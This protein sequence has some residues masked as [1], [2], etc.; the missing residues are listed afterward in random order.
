[1]LQKAIAAQPE[2]A[3][4][5]LALVNLYLRERDF[6][7][8]LN[9][10]QEAAAAVPG[11]SR[12]LDALGRAQLASGDTNQA[13]D[14]FNRLV[15]AEPKSAI[16]LLRL[17]TVYMNRKEPEKAADALVRAQKLA[18]SD[19]NIARDLAVLYTSMGRNDEAM[20]QAKALQVATPRSAAGFVLEGDILANAK[21]NAEAE[22][23]YREALKVE[24]TAG[25]AAIKLHG[26]MGLAGRKA[27]ADAFARKWVSDYPKDMGF[28]IYIA[29][30]ALRA[31]D[32][33]TVVTHYQAVL[34]QQHDNVVALN[35]MAWAM[36][37]LGDPKAM[38]YAERA[39]KLTPDNPSVLDTVGGLL[40]AKGDTAKGLE[41][42]ARAVQLAP[43]R[44]DLRLN[45]AKALMKAGK[46]DEARKELTQLQAV[47]QDFPGKPEVADLLKK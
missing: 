39:L 13:L 7:S 20:K 34:E 30:R 41:Y 9:A 44:H 27:D 6:R 1:V 40:V 38:G 28:R 16:P 2:S 22:K 47:S 4:A 32:Y 3:N 33:K 23:A 8:A 14:S 37:Q 45:Y 25:V 46:R 26:L 24:P 43:D 17:A 18:P 42:M 10:A 11:D 15:T 35:N 21:K 12:I 19:P 29:E 36:G 5:R 31:A